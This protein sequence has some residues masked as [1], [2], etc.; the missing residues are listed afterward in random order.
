M[1]S[2]SPEAAV[3]VGVIGLGVIGRRL[4][5]QA[6]RRDDLQVVAAW[7]IDPAV[8]AKAA[9]DF[10]GTP[11]A[12]EPG[13]WMG[14]SDIDLVYI[15]T[16]PAHHREYARQAGA[17]G[18][19]VLCE[20]PLAA[21]LADG[22]RMRDE[23]LAQGVRHALNFVYASA[24]AADRLLQAVRGGEL[25]SATGIDVRL[26]FSR[27]PRDWQAGADWLRFRAQGGYVREVLSHFVYLAIRLFG[28][29]RLVDA[30]VE[31][32]ADAALCETAAYAR[33]DCAGVPMRVLA[34]AGGGGPDEVQMT[35]R[36]TRAAFRLDNWYDASL[37]S[38][39]EWERLVLPT[40]AG[41][42]VRTAAYQ[43]QLDNVVRLVRG[44]PHPLPDASIGLSVQR[45]IEGI[46][47]R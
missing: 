2:P 6:G 7:D 13:T 5:E 20:K 41:M 29:C 11:I 22:E 36:G 27:W 26:F 18:K 16:P 35:V 40:P 14:R 37:G 45:A 24:P 9:R 34:Q 47:S 21:T 43:A 32:P 4:L 42:D 30:R 17:A 10:P 3:R 15:G 23:L 8:S 28:D 46:L 1:P 25:G 19:V 33:L 44:Q 12:G 39:S 31:W 38:G